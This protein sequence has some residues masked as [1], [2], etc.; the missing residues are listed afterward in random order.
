MR[1]RDRPDSRG[2]TAGSNPGRV[3][4][5]TEGGGLESCKTLTDR[6]SWWRGRNGVGVPDP[7]RSVPGVHRTGWVS[8]R[9][10]RVVVL[11]GPPSEG[12]SGCA[13][14]RT[15]VYVRAGGL[16]RATTPTVAKVTFRGEFV[17]SRTVPRRDGLDEPL[18]DA[19]AEGGRRGEDD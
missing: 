12:R 10:H 4:P 7:E 6:S 15:C 16:G 18:S 17:K 13:R 5:E 3:L 2:G 11:F 8:P 1:R 14:V 9:R 19:A